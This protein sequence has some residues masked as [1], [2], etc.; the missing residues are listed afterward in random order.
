MYTER[1]A[2][3]CLICWTGGMNKEQRT[4]SAASNFTQLI[5]A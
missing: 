1:L 3:S 5:E 4:L 2:V